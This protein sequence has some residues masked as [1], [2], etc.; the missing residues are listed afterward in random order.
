MTLSGASR[1]GFTVEAPHELDLEK[2]TGVDQNSEECT[3]VIHHIKKRGK[4]IPERGSNEPKCFDSACSRKFPR[5][6]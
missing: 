3:G 5:S 1:E 2:Q 4:D 6:E